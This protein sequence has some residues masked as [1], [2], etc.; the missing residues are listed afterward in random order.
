MQ[1]DVTSLKLRRN[2]VVS[3][4]LEMQLECVAKLVTAHKIVPGMY[5]SRDWNKVSFQ[6]TLRHEL[7]ELDRS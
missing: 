2:F 3:I 4:I 7:H 5:D 6:N 1:M